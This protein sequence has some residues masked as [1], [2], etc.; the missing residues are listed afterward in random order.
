MR[1]FKFFSI[2]L[3]FALAVNISFTS[4]S[5]DNDD[6]EN[7]GKSI[8]GKWK[9]LEWEVADVDELDVDDTSITSNMYFTFN[10]DGTGYDL[11]YTGD[12]SDFNWEILDGVIIVSY[13]DKNPST[14][15]NIVKAG[16][17]VMYVVR[18]WRGDYKLYKFVR[19]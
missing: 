8:V 18:E 17:R 5:D 14:T 11:Y 10:S 13:T 2:L 4:C 12:R 6:P 19:I 7:P 9:Y 16:K 1:Q 3:L 15:F